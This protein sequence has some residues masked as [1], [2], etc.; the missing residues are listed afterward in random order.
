MR[1]FATSEHVG[2]KDKYAFALFFFCFFG[3]F[4]ADN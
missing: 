3:V 4:I 1:Y 2:A